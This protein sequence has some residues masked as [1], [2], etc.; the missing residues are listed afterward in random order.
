MNN[1][2]QIINQINGNRIKKYFNLTQLEEITGLSPRALKY[3]MVTVKKK[4]KD[5]PNLLH[6]KKREWQ[7]HYTIVDEFNP[8]YNLKKKT[9]FTQNWESMVTWNPK[10]NYDCDYHYELVSQLKK[11][12][13]ENTFVYAVEKD[14]RGVN[15]THIISN[16]SVS[17]LSDA[18]DS[19]MKTYIQTPSEMRIKIEPL[20]KKYSALE[21]I[22]KMPQIGGII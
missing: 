19:V 6:R 9:L 1:I 3:R 5:M 7:I 14:G 20:I 15:H 2:K 11:R 18:T 21:Y 12:L 8:K 16:A 10:H 22:R 4:Y 17:E 13:P